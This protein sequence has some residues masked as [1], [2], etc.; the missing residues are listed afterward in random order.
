[1]TAPNVVR[2]GVLQLIPEYW[3][4][5]RITSLLV[6]FLN[7]VQRL[8]DAI[9][10]V[11]SVFDLANA[12]LARLKIFGRIVG[13]PQYGRSVDRYRTAIRG[14]ILVNTGQG[15]VAEMFTLLELI[16]PGVTYT[17][18]EVVNALVFRSHA[19]P[20]EPELEAEALALLKGLKGA[21]VSVQVLS[22]A[23]SGASTFRLSRHAQ[24]RTSTGR[25]FGSVHTGA[26]IGGKLSRVFA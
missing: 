20:V 7:E 23:S 17:L 12:D 6:A 26:A 4:K 14:R 10:E 15:R 24:I 22:P 8:E 1:M 25:G 2:E 3:G 9:A 18:T 16:R 5:P 13:E 19:D 21:G 11:E